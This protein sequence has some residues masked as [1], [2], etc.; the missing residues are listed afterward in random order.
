MLL[1]STAADARG[2][3]AEVALREGWAAA[4]QGVRAPAK[5]NGLW[6][7]PLRG[8]IELESELKQKYCQMN[9]D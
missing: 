1:C 3:G 7:E 9:L 2:A 5:Q 8:N 4:P 6:A